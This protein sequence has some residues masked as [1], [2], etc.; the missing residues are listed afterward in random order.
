MTSTKPATTYYSAS[1]PTTAQSRAGDP[2]T[3]PGESIVALLQ[4]RQGGEI[5]AVA[6][7]QEY[8]KVVITQVSVPSLCSP[9]RR[10]DCCRDVKF[11]DTSTFVKTLAFLK[12]NTPYAVLVP[13]SARPTEHAGSRIVE[14]AVAGRN[15]ASSETT[16]LARTVQAE[17]P[18]IA[19]VPVSRK[20]WQ[21]QAGLL[22]QKSYSSRF[23]DPTNS[24]RFSLERLR[25]SCSAQCS[26]S[27]TNQHYHDYEISILRS[28][29]DL[30]SVQVS[31][32][33]R[34]SFLSSF[35]QDSLC[36]L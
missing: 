30:C 25:V 5:G 35:S 16:L 15:T 31:R 4:G 28:V 18:R 22:S 2:S 14:G 17:F 12:T 7:N 3:D 21:E 33:N 34:H 23:P 32:F 11:A 10:A 13:P 1:R 24:L 29:C 9:R 19:I 36:S 20:Y 26:G 8:G 27:R 6:L